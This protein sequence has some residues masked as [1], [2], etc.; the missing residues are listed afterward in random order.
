MNLNISFKYIK[1]INNYI[2]YMYNKPNKN[3]Y[4]KY[5]G[6]SH[7]ETLIKERISRDLI[8]EVY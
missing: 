5:S 8:G 6:E 4:Y 7:R 3:Y 2:F 1:N